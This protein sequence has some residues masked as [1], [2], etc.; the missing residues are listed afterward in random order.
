M[1]KV[2]RN[3]EHKDFHVVM[4]FTTYNSIQVSYQ[5]RITCFG[6]LDYGIVLGLLKKRQNR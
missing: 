1:I 4:Q 2:P 6:V 3:L 5:T